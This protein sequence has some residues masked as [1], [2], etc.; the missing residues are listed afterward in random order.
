MKIKLTEWASMAEIIGALAIVISLVFVGLQ[1]N[2]SNREARA[3]TTQS[4]LDAEIAFQSE[5]L[6]H[7]DIWVTVVLDGDYSDKVK[8]LKA[9]VLFNISMTLLDN[10]FQMMKSGY[11]P[12]SNES[13]RRKV[14]MPFY[15][16]WREAPPAERRSKEF[17]EYM[18]KLRDSQTDN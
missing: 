13:L 6:R 14:A 7:G 10:R 5:L 2:D 9:K 8:L 17:L 4:V 16:I 15:E 18:D 1:I 11:L 12:I 3:A